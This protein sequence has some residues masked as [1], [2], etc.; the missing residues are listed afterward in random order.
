MK[1]LTKDQQQAFY[2]L[3]R[4][5]SIAIVGISCRFPQAKN[6]NEF[7][8]LLHDGIDTVKEIP[9]NRWSIDNYYDPDPSVPGKS[10]QK[11]AAFLENVDDLDPFFFNISPREAY[12][13]SPSQKLS[14]ELAWESLESSGISQSK[15]LGSNTGVYIGNIW[16]DFEHIRKA[17]NAVDT[18]HSAQGQSANL[19][20]NRV[21]Y[22][23]G[24]TGPSLVVDTGCSSSLVA[25]HLAIQSLLDGS[26]DY[27]MVGGINHLLDPDV[28]PSLSKFGALSPSGKCQT[29]DAKA[30]GFV[31]GEGGAIIL[32]K[33]LSDAER[34]GDKIYAVVKGSA[35]NNN[36][37]N[38]SLPATKTDAQKSVILKA[39]ENSGI[40]PSD[41]HFVEAHGT[42]TN[43]GDPVETTAIGEVMGIDRKNPLI[44]GSVK[45]N[46]GHLEG[47]AG[48]AGLLKVILS[49]NNNNIPRNL[50]FKTPNPKIPFD[51][52][53]LK[54]PL[55]NTKWPTLNGETLK[56]GINSFGWGGTNAHAVIEE[57]ISP[58]NITRVFPD[59][60]IEFLILPLSARSEYS[61]RKSVNDY[62]DLIEKAKSIEEVKR[63]CAAAALKKSEFEFRKVFL[64][65][66]KSDLI[67][68]L[69]TFLEGKV[70]I[71]DAQLTEKKKIVFIFPG[72][73][74]QW[75][76]M[77]LELLKSEEVFK[78]ALNECD[79]AFNNYTNWSL[80]EELQKPE[81]KSRFNE[82]DIIQPTIFAIQVALAKL[83]I[84]WGIKPTAVVGHSMGEVAS[85]Y[86]AGSLSLDDAANIICTRSKLMKRCSGK[87]AMAVTEL[88]MSEAEDFIKK[89]SGIS[90]GVNNSPKSTVL[91]GNPD[92]IDS[93]IASLEKKGV[94]C[95]KVNVDVASHSQQMD[96]IKP[97]LVSL[98]KNISPK[99]EKI[100][101]LST[102]RCKKI[103]GKE[104]NAEYWGENLRNPVK[105]ADVSKQLIEEEYT[106][107]LEISPNNVLTYSISESL[108]HWDSKAIAV[109]SLDKKKSEYEALFDNLSKLYAAGNKV[110]WA[111]LFGF[112]DMPYVE[113]PSY[114][115]QREDYSIEGRSEKSTNLKNSSSQFPVLGEEIRLGGLNGAFYWQTY[116]DTITTPYLKEHVINEIPLYPATAYIEGIFE[117]QK[118]LFN[119]T[120]LRIKELNFNKAFALS[121]NPGL[122]QLTMERDHANNLMNFKFLKQEPTSDK[123]QEWAL[124]NNG[125]L[126]LKTSGSSKKDF[127]EFRELQQN[128]TEIIDKDTFYERLTNCD[129]EYG[130]YFQGVEKVWRTSDSVLAKIVP[131]EKFKNISQKFIVHPAFLDACFQSL[132]ALLPGIQN[133]GS[134]KASYLVASI[135]DIQ[136]YKPISY[137]KP[138]WVGA[139]LKSIKIENNF[140]TGRA[141][142]TLYDENR[143]VVLEAGEV[144]FKKIEPEIQQELS[145]SDWLYK[146]N[147]E[148]QSLDYDKIENNILKIDQGP[149][150]VFNE[151]NGIGKYLIERLKSEGHSVCDIQKSKNKSDEIQIND[152]QS[153]YQIAVENKSQYIELMQHLLKKYSGISKIIYCWGIEKEQDLSQSSGN[154]IQA[155]QVNSS[156]SFIYLVQSL[157]GINFSNIPE[158]T[159]VSNGTQSINNPAN[160]NIV[161]S[162]LWGVSK[163]LANEIPEYNCKRF[164]LSY[165]P[166]IEEAEL[167]Y[168]ELFIKDN[169][170]TEIVLR[171]NVRYV[172]RLITV[173]NKEIDIKQLNFIAEASYI[174]TG[175]RGL[176]MVFIEWMFERG[177]RN[178]ML[179]SRSGKAPKDIME[180][181]D[182][183]KKQGANIIIRKADVNN[184]DE[185]EEVFAQVD[186]QM[187]ELK[188][189]IHAA[190][191]IEGRQITDFSFDDFDKITS[192]KVKGTWNLHSLSK[193]KNLDWFVVFSSAS[194]LLGNMGL[195]HYVAGNTFLD[196]FT[197]YRHMQNLPALSINWGTMSDAGMLTNENSVSKF[198]DEEG[199]ELIKMRDAVKVFENVAEQGYKQIGIVRMNIEKVN[200]YFSALSQ[201]NYLSRLS[202]NGIESQNKKGSDILNLLINEESENTKT[203]LLEEFLIEK[204][205]KVI[206]SST[207]KLN[208]T[209][210]FKSLGIDSL[211]AVQLK[212]HINKDLVAKVSV[213]TLWAYPT[214]KEYSKYLLDKVIN[215]QS[216]SSVENDSKIEEPV[217]VLETVELE[218]KGINEL[219]DELN[220]LL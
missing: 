121:E 4:N 190:G 199:F 43:L 31:R 179:T 151:N 216:D 125:I 166:S 75:V 154:I 135:K 19:I 52:F 146:I 67:D 211:M 137:E 30:N 95:K 173:Q 213:T 44:I 20:A 184:Y 156:M 106:T 152:E 41:V 9:A 74:S 5:E 8:R 1:N 100:N 163:V 110:N 99:Q 167:L 169:T 21:S 203:K 50:N 93:A 24:F 128:Y 45:T 139:N 35:V 112:K 177:A 29:F 168:K 140:E 2:R 127:S 218:D 81:D 150:I 189:I 94:Y 55:E 114:K 89:Y 16:H 105:F 160:I 82:I 58:Q 22:T 122:L 176:A 86:I 90:I 204:V 132:F 197:H 76:G 60:N 79:K 198:A 205:A 38:D 36:G 13:M 103:S 104:L 181:I 53:N 47:A 64:G 32:I 115:W 59:I 42:G 28:Y 65:K 194:A 72:Q 85:A 180:R 97:E 141:S 83:W 73:G 11:H 142:L 63:I 17:K 61:F 186:E 3:R 27:G 12:E 159:V 87:G 148:K 49:I 138:V 70:E 212:N 23:Y 214:I 164:D 208:R 71:T 149:V 77:G 92:D 69:N 153:T 10:I 172:S 109:G 171:N 113:L 54:V 155:N 6:I 147:W 126:D 170:E 161:K 102:V 129:F 26:I 91:S 136:L 134:N 124:M 107:F 157:S 143:D 101:I 133:P 40:S 144:C 88:T 18:Q 165:Y 130:T 158:I 131:I 183:L 78:N 206:N 25:L 120:N 185:L 145:H 117:A 220:K 66:G 178:F 116:V 175:F 123:N 174:I 207:S 182:N 80:I 34:D 68:N 191:L 217:Q 215:N 210:T 196:V 193:S 202:S 195:A 119:T 96:E 111:K 39:Y 162:T 201:T 219:S 7:W 98:V 56:A 15:I 46:I 48:M 57:Y 14:L 187:P 84:S 209:M 200:E 192:P 118:A 62:I 51:K 37:Y 188:G 108:A 33:R